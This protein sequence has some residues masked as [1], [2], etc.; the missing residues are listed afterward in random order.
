[1]IVKTGNLFEVDDRLVA[2]EQWRDRKAEVIAQASAPS[3]RVQTA[4]A[5][6]AHAA[7]LGIDEAIADRPSDTA[8]D[9]VEIPGS[10]NR[11]RGA[12]FGSLVHAV[13][14]SVPLN[15]AADHVERAARTHAR[16]LNASD[17][18]VR[19]SVEAVRAVL[20]HD[21]LI[22]ARASSLVRRE[23][24]ITWLHQDGTLTEGVLDLAFEE[25][26]GT[27]VVDFKTDH[28]LAV[29]ESRYRAQ[30]RQYLNA[31]SRV[32]GRPASGVLFR[33]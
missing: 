18:E 5:W 26:G 10:V 11:P 30:L 25:D 1:L 6:A 7:H 3:V 27:V 4:T 14:A 21:L 32:T 16:L 13:L 24:P 28:E 29:G 2:F 33:V 12:R 31:V 22:R 17:E 23:T 15:A 9:I 8:I 19:A 20:D